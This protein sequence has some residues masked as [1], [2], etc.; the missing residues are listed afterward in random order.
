MTINSHLPRLDWVT[1]NRGG[2]RHRLP[3]FLRKGTTG[4]SLFFI[5]GLGG[6]KENFY[7]AFQCP[8]LAHC[9]LLAFD[10]PGTGLAEFDA[11]SCSGVSALAEISQLVWNTLLPQ[12]AFI[13]AASMGGLIALLLIRQYGSANIQGLI[14]IEG[15]LAPEDC[16]FSRRVVEHSFDELSDRLFQQLQTELR[17]SQYPG[18]HMIAH[19]MALN[20]DIRAYH[21]YSFQ[22]VS[23][24]DSGRLL[25]EFLNLT[26]PRLFLYGEANRTLSYLPRLRGSE[27]EVCEI[28]ASAHFLFYDD[29]VT[30]FERIG[31]FVSANSE[32]QDS[33]RSNIE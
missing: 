24:S 19:N 5:H 30:T 26:M 12:P 16:M 29:P 8:Q 21:R 20:T 25:D 33:I 10:L 27:V 4:P 18:D 17:A 15:N 32:K 9:D 6:A 22:T 2:F 14:N 7:A 13:V 28:P 31:K 3:F 1:I 23:E 11:E